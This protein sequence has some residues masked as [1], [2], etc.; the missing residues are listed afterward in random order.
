MSIIIVTYVKHKA[1]ASILNDDVILSL[2]YD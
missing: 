1:T 2:I